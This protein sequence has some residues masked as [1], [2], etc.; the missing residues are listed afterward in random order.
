MVVPVLLLTLGAAAVLFGSRRHRPRRPHSAASASTSASPVAF[1]HLQLFQGGLLSQASLDAAKAELQAKLRQGGPAAAETCLRPGL[2]FVINVRALTAIGT[3]DAGRILERQVSRQI[4][5]DPVEQSW[6]WIDLAGALRELNRVESLPLLLR[7]GERALEG[8]LGHLFAAEMT[9]FPQFADYLTDPIS[10]AGRTALRVLRTAME[11]IRRG[12]VPVTLYAEA[13]IG[14]LVRRLTESCPD[15]ADPLLARV[16]LESLRH[17]R[18]S[19]AASP[20]LREDPI[21]RQAVRWQ[22]SQ[23]RD[24]EP[25]LREYLHD[26]GGDLSHMLPRCSPREQVEILEAIDELHADAGDVLAGMLV[27]P[28]LA[29]RDTALKCLQWSSSM[30]AACLLWNRARQA[31][32]GKPSRSS[33]W[34]WHRTARDAAASEVLAIL[35]ALRGHPGEESGKSSSAPS[36]RTRKCNSGSPPFKALVG[37]SPFSGPKSSTSFIWRE[38]MAGLKS[39][40]RPLPLLGRVL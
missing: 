36:L 14:E 21:R 8:P 29:C 17:A 35:R 12:Y 2:E 40:W 34:R 13:Q 15:H 18:R 32:D 39:E 30:E 6:Y 28:N 19:Y 1:Q 27:E 7:C 22:A 11:G 5:S 31:M 24:A 3:D 9:A 25:V 38:S 37:G 4:S 23:L 20:E 10:L 26:I 33:W 16:F